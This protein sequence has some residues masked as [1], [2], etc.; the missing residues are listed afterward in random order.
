MREI[1]NDFEQEM[2]DNGYEI[3][4]SNYKKAIRG[5]QKKNYR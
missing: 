4:E 1:R 5:F 2:I 3:F